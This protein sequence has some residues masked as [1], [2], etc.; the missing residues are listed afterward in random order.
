MGMQR[1]QINRY[2]KIVG[3]YRRCKCSIL[4]E[5]MHIKQHAAV[6]K[7]KTRH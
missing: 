7:S 3:D 1:K 4:Y 6:L 2:S 5:V